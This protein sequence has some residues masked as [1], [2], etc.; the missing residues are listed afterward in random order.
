M[1]KIVFL[2]SFIIIILPSTNIAQRAFSRLN[3]LNH[4]VLSEYKIKKY[5]DATKL[6]FQHEKERISNMH[7][8]N[9][10][11]MI[12]ESVY[13]G[14]KKTEG[15][16]KKAIKRAF[17]KYAFKENKLIEIEDSDE[18]NTIKLSLD[19]YQNIDVPC[20]SDDFTES[21]SKE[22]TKKVMNE[23]AKGA[24]E[25]LFNYTVYTDSS[26]T[27]LINS[28][29]PNNND[30]VFCRY[31]VVYKDYKNNHLSSIE[32]YFCVIE[33]NYNNGL[34]KS[35]YIL[36]PLKIP[37][38]PSLKMYTSMIAQKSLILSPNSEFVIYYNYIFNLKDN[39]YITLFDIGGNAVFVLPNKSLD[40]FI[41]I[42][43]NIFR[44]EATV[45][46]IKILP[47]WKEKLTIKSNIKDILEAKAAKNNDFSN[48]DNESFA[49]LDDS[50]KIGVIKIGSQ[51][52][53]K[54]NLN[55][56]KMISGK[57][58]QQDNK[59]IEKYCYDNNEENC[60]KYGA[61]YQWEEAM[62]YN[63]DNNRGICPQGWHIPTIEEWKILIEYLG[64][65]KKA[66]SKMKKEEGS[67]WQVYSENNNSSGFS[68][69]P[70]GYKS[71][72]GNKFAKLNIA[73]FMRN[74]TNA[75]SVYLHTKEDFAVFSKPDKMAAFSVRCIK[76]D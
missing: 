56:G 29:N 57:A 25:V 30:T 37:L 52:W 34:L 61:L 35:K 69:V 28:L 66:G 50:T 7:I 3:G 53:M 14:L 24:I 4:E 76:D 13:K 72:V 54:S 49:N 8:Y 31:Q 33:F 23:I 11:T 64:G 67:L 74:S 22:K 41:I 6:P 68:A 60:N 48:F 58:K 59:T 32:D 47:K 65:E 16:K 73:T 63:H 5:K 2:I 15:S 45:D 40:Y 26:R 20:L 12:I 9:A 38:I 17:Y 46:V 27:K 19:R 62:M 51:T 21:E 75:K 39:S 55:I 71:K 1:R 18:I 42:V 36:S 10:D 43:D 70:A 44:K